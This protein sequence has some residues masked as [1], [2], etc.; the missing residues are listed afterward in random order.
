MEGSKFQTLWITNGN[1]T[2]QVMSSL[3]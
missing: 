2:E 3:H 1:S